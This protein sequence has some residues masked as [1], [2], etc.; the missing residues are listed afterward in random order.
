MN[1]KLR[2]RNNLS[3]KGGDSR[4]GAA[5]VEFA[6]VA[7]ILF[8]VIFAGIEFARMTMT[9]SMIEQSAFEAARNVAVLGSTAAEGQAIV[10]EELSYLGI[11]EAEVTVVGLRNG[12]EQGQIDDSTDQISVN[13]VVPFN[14]FILF[15]TTNGSIERTAVINTERL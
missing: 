8:L 14:D 6:L 4:T 1:I 2:K 15:N 13:V 3:R 12:A 5:A 9:I 11:N 10:R 7:P